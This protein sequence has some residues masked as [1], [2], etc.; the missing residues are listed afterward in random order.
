[1]RTA[2][3][4][5]ADS[6]EARAHGLMGVRSLPADAG[7]L[8]VFDA[9]TTAT[10]WMQDTLIPL[11]IAFLADGRVVDILEMSPCTQDPC[12]TYASSAPYT[13]A[14]EMNAGWFGRHGV[15]IGDPVDVRIA[16]S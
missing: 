2:T 9:P 10:F 6:P 3:L 13:Q 12:P 7:M 8:F 4:P 5:V 11:S 15:R 16:S 1:M 14:V